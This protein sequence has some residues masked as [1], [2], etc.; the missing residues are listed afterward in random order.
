MWGGLLFL[1][2]RAPCVFRPTCT[3]PHRTPLNHKKPTA[4]IL[5]FLPFFGRRTPPNPPNHKNPTAS[6]HFYFIFP[7]SAAEPCRT[8]PNHTK[9]AHAPPPQTEADLTMAGCSPEEAP[10]RT[11]KKSVLWFNQGGHAVSSIGPLAVVY[12]SVATM[13]RGTGSKKYFSR[14]HASGS[15]ASP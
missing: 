7:F 6:M 3:E 11:K 2:A 4:N 10:R 14:N 1:A 8:K 13:H 12:I 15:I 9:P 5:N